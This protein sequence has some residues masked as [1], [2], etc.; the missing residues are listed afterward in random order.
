MADN[1]LTDEKRN[2]IKAY[3]KIGLNMVFLAQLIGVH[4]SLISRELK[5]NS[6]LRGY[7]PNPAQDK[8]NSRNKTS[9]NNR[10]F[11]DAVKQRVEFYIK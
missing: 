9:R 7:W 2:K 6:V 10:R 3:L 11:T 5:R 1:Q 8:T 4:N